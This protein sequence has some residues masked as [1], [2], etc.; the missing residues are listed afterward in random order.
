MG[1]ESEFKV[2]ARRRSSRPTDS[3]TETLIA[4]ISGGDNE[5]RKRCQMRG[6]RQEADRYVCG[7][8]MF[9]PDDAVIEGEAGDLFL[10]QREIFAARE[11]REESGSQ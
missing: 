4:S 1:R 11:R 6:F 2:R 8:G 9:L 5:K 3:L 10:R 7:S